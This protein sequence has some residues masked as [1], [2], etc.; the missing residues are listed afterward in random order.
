[1][2]GSAWWE[3]FSTAGWEK[4]PAEIDLARCEGEELFVEYRYTWGLHRF[5]GSNV[6]MGANMALF[7]VYQENMAVVLSERK[8]KNKTFLI[9]A[10]QQSAFQLLLQ[11][12]GRCHPNP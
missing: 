4:V 10:K 8:I 3:Y 6:A 1:M 2:A 11:P 7:G 5:S 12:G 9:S